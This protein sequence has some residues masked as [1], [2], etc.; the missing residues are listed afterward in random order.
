MIKVGL[1]GNI[2]TGKT[3]VERMFIELGIPVIDADDISHKLSEEDEIKNSIIKAFQDDNIVE[4]GVISREK[5]GRVVFNNPQKKQILE[6]ILH[7]KI[8]TE[9]NKFFEKNKNHKIVIASIP[10]IFE[11]KIEKN[12][13]KIILVSCNE[14]LQLERLIKR[15]NLSVENAQ[16]R[17]NCQIPQQKKLSKADYIINNDGT[18][19]D[20]KQQVK[21]VYEELHG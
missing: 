14:Q 15:N 17:I 2:A 1:T 9:I 18:L 13:D 19:E 3:T 5:L 10:L 20:L 8:L 16:Q 4:N 12:F 7:P 21:K 11:L 6:N